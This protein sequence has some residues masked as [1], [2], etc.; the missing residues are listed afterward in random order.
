MK[1]LVAL[2]DNVSHARQTAQ[3]L[4]DVGVNQE[5]THLVVQ[6]AEKKY[7][8]ILSQALTDT[9]VTGEEMTIW[10]QHVEQGGALLVV[11]VDDDQSAEARRIIERYG[12]I[13]VKEQSASERE[14]N[15]RPAVEDILTP[16]EEPETKAESWAML[17]ASFHRHHEANNEPSGFSYKM[18]EPAY[19]YGY[20]LATDR[21]YAERTWEEIEPEAQHTWE[22]SRRGEWSQFKDAVRH[23]W[24]EAT[25]TA[26]WHEIDEEVQSTERGQQYRHL[27]EDRW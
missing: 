5:G 26:D 25:G 23:A 20:Q 17:E 8:T 2:F 7:E 14:T 21:R 12:L 9:A 3:N 22:A 10:R 19:Q 24:S 6:E 4:A 27:K 11:E 16:A 15:E 13:D 1:T 18:Y